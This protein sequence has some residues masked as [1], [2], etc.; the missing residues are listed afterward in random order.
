MN[1]SEWDLRYQ[2]TERLWSPEPNVFVA[3][4]TAPLPPGTALDLG[5]GEGR[6]ARWL[7]SRGWTVTGVDFSAV[8][9]ERARKDAD[10]AGVNVRWIQADVTT[11]KPSARAFDLVVSCYLHLPAA[12]MR[13]ALA[14]AAQALR[15][16]GMLLVV[17]HARVNLTDGVGGPQDPEVLYEPAEV[18]AWLPGGLR[19][20]R[21]EHAYREVEK[22]G[23]VRRAIDTLVVATSDFDSESSDRLQ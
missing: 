13:A 12:E 6:N 3:E 5:C 10:A 14:N 2:E 16:G 20:L 17:G 7:A 4:I 11:W 8:A 21:A 18:V 23:V 1:S 22:E 15:A 19:V 9:L